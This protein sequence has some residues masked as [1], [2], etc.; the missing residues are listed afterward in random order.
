MCI[1]FSMQGSNDQREHT[2]P[3]WKFSDAPHQF[4]IYVEPIATV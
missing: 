4:Q 3:I 1:V 2:I